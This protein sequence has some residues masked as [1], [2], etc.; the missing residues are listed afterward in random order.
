MN[1]LSNRIVATSAALAAC[2]VLLT[3][4]GSGQISQVANQESAVNGTAAKAGKDIVLRNIHLMAN[5]TGDFLQ[6]GKVVPL[7][8]VAANNSAEVDDKLVGISS[9]YG[10]VA[11]GGDGSIPAGRALVVTAKGQNE[12]MGSAT[13]ATAEVTLT[14]PITNGL[15][16]PF[17]FSFEKA[18]SVEVQVP[19]S[20]GEGPRRQ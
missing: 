3:G 17:T 20:A 7:V 8:F 13:P 2:G 14:K 9:E 1:R 12:G 11:V 10:T 15:S 6:P 19:L 5:Q 4:C 16:Y 18:G